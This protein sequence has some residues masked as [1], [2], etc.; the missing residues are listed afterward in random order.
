MQFF[1]V[2]ERKNINEKI[3]SIIDGSVNA[4]WL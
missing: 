3:I 1:T 4:C 2:Q